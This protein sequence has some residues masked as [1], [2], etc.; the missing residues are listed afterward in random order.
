M[1]PMMCVH[2]R[3]QSAVKWASHLQ[4]RLNILKVVKSIVYKTVKLCNQMKCNARD[5]QARLVLRSS[6]CPWDQR[7][8]HTTTRQSLRATEQIVI[9]ELCKYSYRQT[10][11]SMGTTWNSRRMQL[12]LPSSSNPGGGQHAR[13]RQEKQLPRTPCLQ[14]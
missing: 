2:I 10:I 11:L 4:S 14:S 12:A 7:G 3:G 13:A 9:S 8:T 1:L 6:R 5:M